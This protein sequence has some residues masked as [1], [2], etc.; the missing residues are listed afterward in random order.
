MAVRILIVDD[1]ENLARFLQQALLLEFPGGEAVVDL[2]YSGEEGLS[3][4]AA[5][6]YDLIIADYRMPGF[7]GL[8]LVKGVRYLDPYTAIILMTAFGSDEL[9]REAQELG[10][11]QF[12]SKPFE[13]DNMLLVVRQLLPA[14]GRK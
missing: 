3:R 8:E 12:F 9:V 13:I 5:Q 14:Q 7:N 6:S 4:L 2:A 1:E 11:K 10:V